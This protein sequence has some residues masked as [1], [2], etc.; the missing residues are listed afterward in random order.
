MEPYINFD[1]PTNIPDF[2][3]FNGVIEKPVVFPIVSNK[4][5]VPNYQDRVLPVFGPYGT[6]L[7]NPTEEFRFITS[8]VVPN[9]MYERYLISNFGRVFDRALNKFM[10]F[11]FNKAYNEDGTNDGYLVFKVAYYVD[12]YTLAAKDVYLHRAVMITFGGLHPFYRELEVNHKDGVKTHNY[13]SNLEWC[14]PSWNMQHAYATGLNK[15][16]RAIPDE[17]VHE[18]CHRLMAGQTASQIEKEM[19]INHKTIYEIKSGA[20]YEHITRLYDL[21]EIRPTARPIDETIVNRICQLRASGM[22]VTE[23]CNKTHVAEHVV[24]DIVYGRNYTHISSKYT[25][26]EKRNTYTKL[27]E[28]QV[29]QIVTMMNNGVP[30]EEIS[31]QMNLPPNTLR[32]IR[33]GKSYKDIT[34]KLGMIYEK[35]RMEFLTKSRVEEICQFIQDHRDLSTV[36]IAKHLG[37]KVHHVKAIRLR[38]TFVDISSKYHW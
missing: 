29:V 28:D 3:D 32:G 5:K 11:H 35:P 36:A 4:N 30:D 2:G 13:I 14:T 17:K 34:S 33:K 25:F 10:T 37:A 23:I 24:K 8:W 21:P 26:P 15:G 19:G 6:P 38:K 31:K 1:K 9:I 20:V 22:G 27:T 18:I 16:N 12:M 7:V